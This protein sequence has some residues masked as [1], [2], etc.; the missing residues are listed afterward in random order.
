MSPTHGANVRG[1]IWPHESKV[2]VAVREGA[3]LR[4][5][6]LPCPPSAPRYQVIGRSRLV[7]ARVTHV[8]ALG[9]DGLA[10]LHSLTDGLNHERDDVLESPLKNT[11]DGRMCDGLDLSQERRVETMITTGQ[12]C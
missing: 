11:V 10:S 12:T 4:G 6:R 9:G 3:C 1:N 8:R 7:E 5:G 2:Y